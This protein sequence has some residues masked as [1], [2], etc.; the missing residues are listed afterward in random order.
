[1]F[2]AAATLFGGGAFVAVTESGVWPGDATPATNSATTTTNAREG[3]LPPLPSLPTVAV[4]PAGSTSGADVPAGQP[5]GRLGDDVALN[6]LASRCFDAVMSACDDLVSS[7][8]ASSA[9]RQYGD[10]CGGRRPE[11]PDTRCTVAFPR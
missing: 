2:L 10:S 6:A 7:A 11:D 9:Y 4:S 1:M 5:P 8:P 3:E